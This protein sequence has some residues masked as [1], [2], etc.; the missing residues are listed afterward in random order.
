MKLHE[1]DLY[2]TQQCNLNCEFCSVDAS[3]QKRDALTTHEIIELI[4]DTCLLG[5]EDLH[6]T[7][8]EPLLR[9]DIEEIIAHANSKGLNVRLLTNGILLTDARLASLYS[10][11]LRN[12]MISMDGHKEINDRVRCKG[13]YDMIIN[14]INRCLEL[15]NFQVRVN[16]VAW[17][18]NLHEIPILASELGSMGVH[19]YSVFL[20]SPLGRGLTWKN[21]VLSP[22]DWTKLCNLITQS[23]RIKES[24]TKI[25]IEKAFVF[26]GENIEFSDMCGRG[27]GCYN[28]TNN[29][30]FILVRANGD[31]YPCVFFSNEGEPMG[32]IHEKPIKSI[33]QEY[34]NMAFY[35]SAGKVPDECSDC[36]KVS[37]CKGGC[38]GYAHIYYNNWGHRDPRCS[39]YTHNE[40]AENDY[41]PV[42]PIMKLNINT[43]KIGGSSE[44]VIR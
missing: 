3:T 4:D 34:P 40:D 17:K 13:S 27:V 14:A 43:G 41:F 8:G 7:G 23:V 11:G 24:P 28:I 2:V 42:C 25:I 6:L 20:G 30:D 33:L 10:A 36:D 32:N 29:Y 22:S 16:S 38:R 15:E 44:Q 39:R 21:E 5:L 37:I 19:T 31:I 12:I 35:N 9:D 18:S 1:I 26:S